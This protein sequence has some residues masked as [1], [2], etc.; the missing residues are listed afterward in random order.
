MKLRVFWEI[1]HIKLKVPLC[2]AER[3]FSIGCRVFLTTFQVHFSR[4]N[5]KKW[6]LTTQQ[7]YVMWP[8]HADVRTYAIIVNFCPLSRCHNHQFQLNM[9]SDQLRFIVIAFRGL[10]LPQIIV[11]TCKQL[12]IYLVNIHVSSL[13]NRPDQLHAWLSTF[14][15]LKPTGDTI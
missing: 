1:L 10:T 4:R 11:L 7:V 9:M 15:G 13:N 6:S 5:R 12:S 14:T 2:G 3:H 8:S